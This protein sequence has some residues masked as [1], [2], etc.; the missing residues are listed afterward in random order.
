VRGEASTAGDGATPEP[1]SGWWRLVVAKSG[2][3]V[4][5]G[6]LDF[7]R[8]LARA[9][10]RAGL[11]IEYSRG[12]HPAPRLSMA[13]P[14]PLGCLG[15]AEP[16][17][18]RLGSFD[19]AGDD[20][21]ARLTR[22]APAGVAFLSLRPLGEGE[23]RSGRAAAAAEYLAAVPGWTEAAAAARVALLESIDRWLLR[24]PRREKWDG[25]DV[26]PE[27]RGLGVRAVPPTAAS[28]LPEPAA[29]G[30]GFRLPLPES[31]P[32]AAVV[33]A[34]LGEVAGAAIVIRTGIL[35]AAG[36]PLD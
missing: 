33:A 26:R 15:L 13:A 17:D 32:P 28:R 12:F 14:L 9:F 6:H 25:R 16:G 29:W 8:A 31:P 4:W 3:A 20:G 27:I 35:D 22:S 1:T 2:P 30:L 36:R 10:R 11:P 21:C 34:L 7:S 5:A 19:A 23:S 18:V 24:D